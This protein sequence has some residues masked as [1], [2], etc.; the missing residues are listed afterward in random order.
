MIATE[1]S[2]DD[3]GNHCSG[4]TAARSRANANEHERIRMLVERDGPCAAQ[5]WVER[6]LEIYREAVASPASHASTA[7]Y[8]PL[9]EASI[10]VFEQWL[11]AEASARGT[12]E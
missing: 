7:H 11:R 1:T 2:H 10:S 4:A 3:A 8:R 6:T 9:F 5:A 12:N